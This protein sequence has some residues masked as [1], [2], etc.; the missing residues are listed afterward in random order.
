[1]VLLRISFCVYCLFGGFGTY[2]CI[3]HL[4][5]WAIGVAVVGLAGLMAVGCYFVALCFV[6]CCGGFLVVVGVTFVVVM[7]VVVPCD[8]SAL[9]FWFGGFGVVFVVFVLVWWLLFAVYFVA[10]LF[11]ICVFGAVCVLGSGFRSVALRDVI[12]VL[13]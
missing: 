12:V 7:V 10:D 6:G 1:M 9:S 4:V 11:L 5:L 8:G 13:R 3:V 2:L